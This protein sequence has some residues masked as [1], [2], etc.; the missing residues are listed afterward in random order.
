[1]QTR[2]KKVKFSKGQISP[3]LVERTDLDLLNSS[4]Q[5]MENVVSTIYGG[6]RTRRGT[7]YIDIYTGATITPS[8]VTSDLGGNT[9]D[10]ITLTPYTS[11]VLSNNKLIAKIDYGET[12]TGNNVISIKNLL[13]TFWRVT[14][15][16]L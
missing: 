14:M 2:Q 9:S 11:A 10:I 15:S 7:K 5:K 8:G 4:A 3:E 12:L 16:L 6:V 13:S 1:M